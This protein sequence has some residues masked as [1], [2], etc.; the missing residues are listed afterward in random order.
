MIG[1]LAGTQHEG[2]SP[3]G[4]VKAFYYGRIACMEVK[5]QFSVG[6]AVGLELLEFPREFGRPDM[7]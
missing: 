1:P 4:Q 3:P 6:L 2:I 5:Y 7:A